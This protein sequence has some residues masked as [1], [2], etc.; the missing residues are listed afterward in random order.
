MWKVKEL[1]DLPKGMEVLEER[2]RQAWEAVES[3]DLREVG[4][5]L[6]VL[7]RDVEKLRRSVKDLRV[8]RQ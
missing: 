5:A 7:A 8:D 6:F 1:A 4:P 3:G 2:M